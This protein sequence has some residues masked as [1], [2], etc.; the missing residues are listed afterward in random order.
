MWV[1]KSELSV[2]RRTTFVPEP[3]RLATTT[4]NGCNRISTHHRHVVRSSSQ[5]S[6]YVKLLL[7]LFLCGLSGLCLSE[8]VQRTWK[9]RIYVWVEADPSGG[10]I[11]AAADTPMRWEMDPLARARSRPALKTQK[12]C[13]SQNRK[14]K[15]ITKTEIPGTPP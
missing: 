6:Q 10:G 5:V 3:A 13:G 7:L 12:H 8:M 2:E 1:G 15:E 14:K 9:R 4:E 11:G